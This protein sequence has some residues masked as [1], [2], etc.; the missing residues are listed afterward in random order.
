M[1]PWAKGEKVQVHFSVNGADFSQAALPFAYVQEPQLRSVRVAQGARL[2]RGES[3]GRSRPHGAH[4]QV[5]SMVLLSDGGTK[6][7]LDGQNIEDIGHTPLKCMFFIGTRFFGDVDTAIRNP[8]PGQQR[9]ATHPVV[10]PVMYESEQAYCV[11][12][13]LYAD[14]GAEVGRVL[15]VLGCAKRLCRC[16]WRLV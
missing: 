7:F 3:E 1:P 5:S 6:L 14:E 11:T 4:T 2:E 12:P 15:S 9:L 16:P 10:V 13:A 8:V